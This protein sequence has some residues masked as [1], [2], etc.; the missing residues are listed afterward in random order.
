MTLG[1]MA[2][3]R[4]PQGAVFSVWQ[5]RGSIGAQVWAE[6]NAAGWAELQTT[7]TDAATKFYTAVFPWKPHPGADY[8]EWH[9]NGKGIGGLM[10]IGPE[11]GPVP[12]HWNIY[13][14][15]DDTDAIF[16][17]TK[18]MGGGAHLPPMD[19]PGVGRFAILHDA[20]GAVFAV[21]KLTRK[22]EGM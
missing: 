16:A 13:F 7:D 6:T 22:H 11:W 1:R 8:T 14:E 10:K 18:S 9:L 4:D 15:V 5:P 17:K 21:I 19:F 3:I 2:V 12:P 20:Q